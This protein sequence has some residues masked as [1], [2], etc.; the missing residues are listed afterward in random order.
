MGSFTAKL[1]LY[2]GPRGGPRTRHWKPLFWS[3]REA[4]VRGRS[5]E[6]TAQNWK[7]TPRGVGGIAPQSGELRTVRTRFSRGR[8]QTRTTVTLRHGSGQ[9]TGENDRGYHRQVQQ[10]PVHGGPLRTTP[11]EFGSAGGEVKLPATGRGNSMCAKGTR[12][13]LVALLLTFITTTRD[14]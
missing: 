6:A 2:K 12:R 13:A 7:C 11:G 8:S 1:L 4:S 10:E 14:Y 9:N 5:K 3:P